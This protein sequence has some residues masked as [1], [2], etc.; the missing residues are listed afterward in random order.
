MSYIQSEIYTVYCTF[1]SI[2]TH[3]LTKITLTV[4]RAPKPCK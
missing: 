2:G 3:V 1:T 4:F